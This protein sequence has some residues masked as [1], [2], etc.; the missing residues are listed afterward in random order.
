[1]RASKIIGIAAASLYLLSLIGATFAPTPGSFGGHSGGQ[2]GGG[3]NSPL[4]IAATAMPS[5]FDHNRFLGSLQKNKSNT[6]STTTPLVGFS[7]NLHHT[8]HL[9]KYIAAI[10]QMAKLGINSLQILTPAFQKHGGSEIIT[11]PV[12]PGRCP[13]AADI[14][15]L[16]RHAK[17]KG[18]RTA[19]MPTVLFTHPRGNEWRG[20][21]SP[22]RWNPWW[23][24]Y[25]KTILHFAKI[26]QQ[27]NV[28]LFCIGSELLSTEQQTSRWQNLITQVRQ[29][30][31]GQLVYSTNWDHFHVPKFWNQL[32]HI[33]ISGYWDMTTHTPAPGSTSGGDS[34]VIPVNNEKHLPTDKQLDARWR[35]IQDQI[36]AFAKHLQ[37][38]ILLTELGY[39]TLSWA[40]KSPWNYVHDADQKPDPLPQAKGYDAFCRAWP[41]PL[42]SDMA[43]VFFYAWDPYHQGGP[44]DTGYGIRGKPAMKILQ[45]WLQTPPPTPALP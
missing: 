30:F 38:P 35:E 10:D 18:L 3:G 28:D 42:P 16:L 29:Q 31:H 32:D 25:E 17:S 36:L 41:R 21:I 37:K 4:A 33:G 22:P 26:A 20:K 7:I 40:L 9:P 11:L 15:T 24:S 2:S 44:S 23:Q 6:P 19:L 34:G 5:Q 45:H 12:G 8:E 43:G 1:M 27:A 13:S 14:L 39:P